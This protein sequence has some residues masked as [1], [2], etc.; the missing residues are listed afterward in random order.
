MSKY[1]LEKRSA[2]VE[3]LGNWQRE[4]AAVL[5]VG[6]AQMTAQG[7]VTILS[8]EITCSVDGVKANFYIDSVLT[9]HGGAFEVVVLIRFGLDGRPNQ[10]IVIGEPIVLGGVQQYVILAT[11]D[12]EDAENPMLWEIMALV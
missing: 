11:S 10:Y 8:G 9:G 6:A 12:E 1:T 2:L 4:A 3:V 7:E 5:A